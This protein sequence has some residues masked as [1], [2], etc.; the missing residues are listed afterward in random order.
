MGLTEVE[1]KAELGDA[2]VLRPLPLALPV[3]LALP[4]PLPLTLTLTLTLPLPSLPLPLPLPRCSPRCPSRLTRR[5]C[6]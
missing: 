2:K 6:A 4:L 3:T 5:P 1:A